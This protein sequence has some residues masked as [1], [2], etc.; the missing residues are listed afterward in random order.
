[1]GP[2]DQPTPLSYFL[3]WWEKYPTHEFPTGEARSSSLSVEFSAQSVGSEASMAEGPGAGDLLRAPQTGSRDK[4]GKEDPLG[5]LQA[6]PPRTHFLQSGFTSR[7]P[8]SYKVISGL[9]H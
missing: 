1:M 4:G 5:F 2:T 3:P 9:I 8:P 6:T 7:H